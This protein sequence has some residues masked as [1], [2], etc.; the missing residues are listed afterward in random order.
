LELDPALVGSVLSETGYD[1]RPGRADVASKMA[2]A[3]LARAIDVSLLDVNLQDPVLRL[4]RLLNTSGK[5]TADAPVLMPLIT[6]EIIYRLLMGQQSARLRHVAV[7]GGY[8]SFITRAVE[9]LRKDFDQ[10]IHMNDLASELGVSVSGQ[11]HHF[12]AVTSMSPL[13]F[14]KQM[15]LQEARR[16]VTCSGCAEKPGFEAKLEKAQTIKVKRDGDCLSAS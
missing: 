10:P 1:A 15:R 16:C 14:L 9:R 3:N 13:Q 6:R 11:N 12:K 5:P 4:V 8:T 7:M 2:G